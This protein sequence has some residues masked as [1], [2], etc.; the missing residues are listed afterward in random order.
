MQ[1]RFLVVALF[2][3]VSFFSQKILFVGNSLTYTN[4][5]PQILEFIGDEYNLD[6]T[7]HCLCKPNYAI[8]DHLNEQE[9]EQLLKENNFDFIIAQQGPSSQYEGKQLLINGGRILKD[10]AK[11]YN[12]EFRYFMVWTSKKWYATF[13]KVIENHIAAAR[14]NNVEVFKVGK[15]W[16]LYTDENSYEN[17]YG[18]DG[19]HP[20]KAGSLLAGLTIFHDLFPTKNLHD[21]NHEDF[22][23]FVVDQK[24][25][26]FMIALISQN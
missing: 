23:S 6:I 13:N 8:I 16:K 2:L 22:K 21:L 14:R 15:I 26:D 4:N 10:L 18:V 9:L 19:F 12:A 7:T 25:F 20:S 11:K 3:N 17:L 5:L 1:F 24:S